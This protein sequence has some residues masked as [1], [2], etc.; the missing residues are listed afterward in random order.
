MWPETFTY[1]KRINS[2]TM[3]T[4]RNL[5]KYYSVPE[6]AK[7]IGKTRQ[8]VYNM[9]KRKELSTEKKYGKTLIVIRG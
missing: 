4:T 6:Y 1:C 2:K 9:I 5:V 3:E 8:T 7:Y